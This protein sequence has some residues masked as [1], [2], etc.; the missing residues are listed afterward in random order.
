MVGKI[1]I[2]VFKDLTLIG[3]YQGFKGTYCLHFQGRSDSSKFFQNGDIV[4]C[5]YVV[6]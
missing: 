3:G 2:G 6:S 5:V 1:H 4:L